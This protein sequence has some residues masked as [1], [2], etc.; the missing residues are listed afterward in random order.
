MVVLREGSH[1]VVRCRS[2]SVPV[3]EVSCSMADVS[4]LTV[5]E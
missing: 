1:T 5:L 2:R 4:L 3:E